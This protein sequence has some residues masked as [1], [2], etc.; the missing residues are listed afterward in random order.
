MS[1]YYKKHQFSVKDI[2]C[3]L[4]IYETTVYKRIRKL[5]IV[6]RKKPFGKGLM[7]TDEEFKKIAK[8]ESKEVDN[9]NILV[10]FERYGTFFIVGSSMNLETE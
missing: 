7:L 2:A 1:R 3:S 8:F 10:V 6:G 5:S 4:N 9:D